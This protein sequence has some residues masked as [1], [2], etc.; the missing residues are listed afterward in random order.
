MKFS[1]HCAVAES[2]VEVD[3]GCIQMHCQICEGLITYAQYAAFCSDL[4][5]G[6][7]T[8]VHW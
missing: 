2:L 8:A 7:C 1:G 6:H 5:L 4:K 3:S